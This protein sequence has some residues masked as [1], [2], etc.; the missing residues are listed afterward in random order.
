M[1]LSCCV[2]PSSW[3]SWARLG[4]AG[5]RQGPVHDYGPEGP[6]PSQSRGRGSREKERRGKGDDERKSGKV[7]MEGQSGGDV[8]GTGLLLE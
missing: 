6:G 1:R 5:S 8:V 7:W 4:W 3:P 2:G